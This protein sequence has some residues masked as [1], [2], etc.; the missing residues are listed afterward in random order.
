MMIG[1]RF[2]WKASAQTLV[3][4]K[5]LNDLA[6]E[7]HVC[8]V[9]DATKIQ[10]LKPF[11]SAVRK[12]STGCIH[13]TQDSA[14]VRAALECALHSRGN[15]PSGDGRDTWIFELVAQTFDPIWF[16]YSI[17]IDVC[18]YVAGRDLPAAI[19]CHLHSTIRHELISCVSVIRNP[20]GRF[21]S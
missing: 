7:C 4:R 9:R 5:P 19:S 16:G 3:E 15:D 20:H 8:A 18:D 17:I 1:K 11:S 13:R 6:T 2:D 10:C 12:G 21:A 14:L